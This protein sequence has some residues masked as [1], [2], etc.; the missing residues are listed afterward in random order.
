MYQTVDPLIVEI[1]KVLAVTSVD[2]AQLNKARRSFREYL[3]Q[4]WPNLLGSSTIAEVVSEMT[5]DTRHFQNETACLIRYLAVQGFLPDNNST[6]SLYRNLAALVERTLPGLSNYFKLQDRKQNYEKIDILTRV[7]S[8][9]EALLNPLRNVP[10]EIAALLNSKQAVFS[11]LNHSAVRA[12]CA[13]FE[14]AGGNGHIETLFSRFTRLN[15]DSDS[16]PMD[17]REAQDAVDAGKVFCDINA[18]FLTNNFI[19]PFFVCASE[20][21]QQFVTSARA[22]L[23]SNIVARMAPNSALQKRYPLHSEGR[24]IL[25]SIPFRNAGPSRAIGVVA[26]IEC[27]LEDIVFDKNEIILGN[28]A[29]GD[30]SLIARAMII[31]P[32]TE[33]TIMVSIA[34][35]EAGSLDRKSLV[36]TCNVN[37]QIG[38]VDWGAMKYARPYKTEVAKGDEFVGRADLVREL[39]SKMLQV[40]MEPFY[41]TGQKRVGKTS[42]VLAAGEFAKANHLS[43]ELHIC[44]CLWGEFAHPNPVA[45]VRI[46]GEKI[47]SIILSTLPLGRE[48]PGKLE[49]DGSLADLIRL[50]RHAS[51]VEPEN[52]YVIILDEFDE[53]H[54]ELYIQG[55]LAETFFANLRALSAVS[56]VCLALVGGEN[57]PFVMDRQG[58]KLNRFVRVGLDYFSRDREWPDFVTLVKRPTAGTIHWHDEAISE[59]FNIANGNPYFAKILCA[60]VFSA[61]VEERDADLTTEE[62]VRATARQVARLDTNSFSHLWQDG[63]YKS[64]AE[65]DPDILRRKRLLVAIARVLRSGKPLIFE[66]IV[67]SSKFSLLPVHEVAP[68]VNEFLRRRILRED[69]G[70]YDFVLPV[71]RSWLAEVG[72]TQLAFDAI[73]EELARSAQAIEDA[74]YVTATEREELVRKWPPYQGKYISSDAVK[75]WLGQVNTNRKQRLLFT[76]LQNVHFFDEQKVRTSLRT[77]H[78]LLRAAI[79]QFVQK[80][81]SQRRVD[82]IVTYVDGEGK[83]GQYYAS[84]Y[85]EENNIGTQSIIS[86]SNFAFNFREYQEKYGKVAAIVIVDDIVATGRSWSNNI[87]EF[88]KRCERTLREAN[89]P[90]TAVALTATADGEQRVRR[91]LDQIDWLDIDLRVCELLSDESF[92]FKDE[93]GIWK[94]SDDKDEAKALCNDI[95]AR[96][97]PNN[98]L[99]FGNQGL[100]IVFPDTCPNNT[101]PIFHS[102]NGE[103]KNRWIP[104]F[105]RL[106]N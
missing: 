66:N 75:A 86:S 58:Q 62:V 98:P 96:I 18:T 27:D 94:H 81:R 85:A 92:A 42:L 53:I 83:S 40:P 28:I 1:E 43:A 67:E 97:Y 12:Y 2:D 32:V 77:A 74:S 102:T 46:L 57:M 47:A 106:T 23:T 39:S 80:K 38:D 82:L 73:G 44:Y 50:A 105:P 76:L 48:F 36:F 24:E 30:F 72:I 103:S 99:G 87:Q 6:N 90:I 71:F 9:I 31:K 14:I 26:G 45:S 19:H 16:L 61:A 55:N 56:N 13:P 49:F 15:V 51:E 3:L 95:G 100:L 8:N 60:E 91:D 33:I 11:A 54:Q 4:K 68:V 65:R 69:H 29:P 22:R 52:K 5:R 20:A 89:V 34:W 17:V 37:S 70:I 64:V 78:G 101:L 79:P 35:Q 41:V 88:I 84:K 10:A 59:I 104:L 63:I 21:L 25:L 93:N 7:H